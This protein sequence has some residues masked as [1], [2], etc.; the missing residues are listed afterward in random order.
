MASASTCRCRLPSRRTTGRC[1]STSRC[2][3]GSSATST[4]ASATAATCVT[5][6]VALRAVAWERAAGQLVQVVLTV[7]V[8]LALP[9]PVRSFMPLVAVALVV[10][11]IGVVLVDRARP[12][13]GR[14]RWARLRSAV[15]ARRPRRAARPEGTA[16]DR[17]RVRRGR[18]RPR[19]HVPDR[20]AGRRRHRAGL[21]DAA[22]GVPRDARHGAAQRRRLGAARGGDGVGV[23]RGRAWVPIEASPPP[24]RT[25]SW[26]SSPACRARSCSSG[27]GSLVPGVRRSSKRR[28]RAGSLSSFSRTEPRDA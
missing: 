25:A 7:V 16:G 27:R 22:A 19:G 20:R 23:R 11:A 17:A 3:A 4:A 24:S 9:S 14:S 12:G 13:G 6:A 21:P 2:P 5:S 10:T 15:A 8:L 28:F 26:C 18:P 1:S